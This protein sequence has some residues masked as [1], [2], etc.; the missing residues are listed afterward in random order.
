MSWFDHLVRGLRAGAMVLVAS[1]A[2]Q[3]VIGGQVSWKDSAVVA[4]LVTAV[5]AGAS[6]YRVKQAAKVQ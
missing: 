5:E 3:Q 6:A 1:P 4:A 2:V